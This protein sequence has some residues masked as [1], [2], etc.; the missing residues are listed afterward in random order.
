MRYLT[1]SMAQCRGEGNPAG[2]G[3]KSGGGGRGNEAPRRGHPRVSALPQYNTKKICSMSVLKSLI[4]L[5]LLCVDLDIWAIQ[6]RSSSPAVAS[7]S[8]GLVVYRYY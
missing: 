8:N 5:R 2:A 3:R 1:L 7:G 6:L 4:S